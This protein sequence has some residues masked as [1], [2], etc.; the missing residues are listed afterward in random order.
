[1]AYAQKRKLPKKKRSAEKSEKLT[2]DTEEKMPIEPIDGIPVATKN[3]PV[4]ETESDGAASED[5][6]D[7]TDD[8]ETKSDAEEKMDEEDVEEAAADAKSADDDD[9][10]AQND[11]SSIYG[12]DDDG[13]VDM[14]KLDQKHGRR[15]WI[16][17]VLAIVALLGIVVYLGYRVFHQ[18]GTQDGKVHLAI[19]AEDRVASGDVVSVDITYTNTKNVTLSSGTIEVFYPDG[20]QPQSAQP[21]SSDG[22][23]RSWTIKNVAPGAGGKIRIVGQLVGAKDDTKEFSA[24][25]TYRPSNF[26]QDFQETAKTSVTI[27]SSIVSLSVDA[28]TQIASNQELTYKVE[29]TNTSKNALNNIKMTMTY[30]DGFTF[31]SASQTPWSENNEWRIDTLQAGETQTLEIKGTLTGDNG[32]TKEFAFQLGLIEIDNSFDVQVSKTSQIVMVNPSIDLSIDTSE[33]AQ[34]GDEVAVNVNIK[35]TSDA[36]IKDVVVQLSMVGAVDGEAEHTFDTIKELGAG[37]SKTLTTN[38]TLK[39]AGD[40]D[41]EV[42]LTAV[43]NEAHVNGS[44]V[45]FPDDQ[46]EATIKIG[47]TLN[48]SAEGRYFDDDL[49]KIGSGPIPPQVGKKTTYVIQWSLT[50]EQNSMD[51]VRVVTTL[52]DNVTWEDDA[53]S[54]IS[55]DESTQQV[56]YTKDSFSAEAEVNLRFSVSITPVSSDVNKLMVLTNETTLTAQNTFTDEQVTASI[57][58]ITTDLPNDEG[59]AGK[60]VVEK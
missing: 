35:N 7:D 20:F 16:I 60:G 52:P 31:A 27:T 49:S 37:E 28:P 1:M 41:A 32:A 17:G 45:T 9:A 12:I 6:S 26:S 58:R 15:R 8:M 54:A 10:E 22:R 47:G 44:S 18:G 34:A 21:E 3:I 11:L 53:S 39:S 57:P 55:Y 2:V 46:A 59:A 14:T 24:V 38:I 13:P 43:V 48:L 51:T 5:D 50:N 42:G 36:K 19:A 29:Y 23:N 56:S 4:T 30:P 25:M 33:V 40:N